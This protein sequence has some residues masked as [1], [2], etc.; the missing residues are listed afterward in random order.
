MID[1]L[2]LEEALLDDDLNYFMNHPDGVARL[3]EVLVM[4][5]KGYMEYTVQELIDEMNERDLTFPMEG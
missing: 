2:V 1:R 5:H 3:A 4:G